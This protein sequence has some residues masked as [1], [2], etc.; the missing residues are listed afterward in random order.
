L[1]LA[2]AFPKLFLS[3]VLFADQFMDFLR[4]GEVNLC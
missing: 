1:R 2:V 3:I 4:S